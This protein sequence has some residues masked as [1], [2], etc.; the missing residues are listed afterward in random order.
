MKTDFFVTQTKNYLLHWNVSSLFNQVYHSLVISCNFRLTSEWTHIAKAVIK[1]TD[2]CVLM[3]CYGTECVY[4]VYI[5]SLHVLCGQAMNEKYVQLMN[6]ETRYRKLSGIRVPMQSLNWNYVVP[7]IIQMLSLLYVDTISSHFT[8]LTLR[9]HQ[10][11]R[12]SEINI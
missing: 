3:R 8:M 10:L 11:R 4:N 6:D 12:Q 5:I 1:N 9:Q 2:V 7:C